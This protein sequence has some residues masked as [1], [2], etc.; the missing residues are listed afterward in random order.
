MSSAWLGSWVG[1]IGVSLGGRG[2]LGDWIT[3]HV[4]KLLFFYIQY[5]AFISF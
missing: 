1:D 3:V 2:V 5:I 4:G